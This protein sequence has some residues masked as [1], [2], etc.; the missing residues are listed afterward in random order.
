MRE[1]LKGWLGER[2]AFVAVVR[3]FGTNTMGYYGGP[4]VHT[5]LLEHVQNSDGEPLTDHVWITGDRP[6]LED[7][8]QSG[9]T[10]AFTAIV[11]RYE[12]RVKD[13]QEDSGYMLHDPPT[14]PDYGLRDIA[15]VVILSVEFV[16]RGE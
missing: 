1:V 3:G 11:H 2:K 12:K 8:F 15:D 14:I 7:G 5:M 13:W 16:A 6:F 4:L 9:D 10:I